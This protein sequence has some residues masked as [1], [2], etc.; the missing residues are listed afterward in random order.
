MNFIKVQILQYSKYCFGHPNIKKYVISEDKL[1]ILHNRL[2]CNTGAFCTSHSVQVNSSTETVRSL[3][4]V[5]P[6]D[7]L[8]NMENNYWWGSTSCYEKAFVP[9]ITSNQPQYSSIQTQ[10]THNNLC[11]SSHQ[12]LFSCRLHECQWCCCTS[13][14]SVLTHWFDYCSGLLGNRFLTSTDHPNRLAASGSAV[15]LWSPLRGHSTLTSPSCHHSL[16]RA[17]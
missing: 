15:F 17:H 5:S 7:W 13:A 3:L 2:M 12:T 4:C 16:C 1:H 9:L 14:T 11:I 6:A 10:W 8:V